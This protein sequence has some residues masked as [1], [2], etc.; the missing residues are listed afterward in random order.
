[1]IDYNILIKNGV[2]F[3]H[4]TWRWC[5]KMRPYIWGQKNDVHLIDVSK[6]AFQL[7]KAAKFLE[8]IASE[9]KPVLWVGTKRAASEVVRAAAEKAQSP[10]VTHR[11]VGGTITNHS[12]VK[13]SVT[14]LLHFEDILSKMSEHIY[15]KKEY[16]VFSKIVDR[17]TKSVG[18]IRTLLWPIGA[19]VVF[20]VKKEHVAIKEAH[21]AGIPVVALVDTNGDPSGI[22][23]VIPGNDDVPR[24]IE[25]IASYLSEAVARGNAVAEARPKEEVSGDK[26][27]EQLVDRALSPDEEEEESKKRGAR[28]RPAGAAAPG[29]A[30]T[31]QRR[32]PASAGSR[33]G[34]RPAGARRPSA[35]RPAPAKDK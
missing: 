11:W 2:Q 26:L 20:D 6:T 12:Q 31:G 27:I 15:T 35:P 14:R 9:G 3:G 29:A 4:L 19:V 1:M 28:R 16:G 13:K 21:A 30:P 24:A 10:Y 34:Q 7:E 8:A 23:Y 5:P 22:D 17:L 32:R 18:G 33:G 25:V